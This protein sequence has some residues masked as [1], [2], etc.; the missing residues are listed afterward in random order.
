M[1][2]YEW[3]LARMAEK[4]PVTMACRAAEVSRQAF[5]DWVARCEAGPS[6]RETAD[7]AITAELV[8]IHKDSDRTYG[9]PRLHGELRRRGRCVNHK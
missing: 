1:T 4:F 7:A 5:Y 9:R 2:R 8:E 6:V 3:V